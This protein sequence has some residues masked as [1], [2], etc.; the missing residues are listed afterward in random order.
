MML[1]LTQP[2]G[3]APWPSEDLADR[4]AAL[5]VG[6]AEVFQEDDRPERFQLG[7]GNNWWLHVDGEREWRLSARYCRGEEIKALGVVIEYLL[8]SIETEEM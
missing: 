4:L 8:G 6:R 5:L 7:A 1:R 3:K 2:G